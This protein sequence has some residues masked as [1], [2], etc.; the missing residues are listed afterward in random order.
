MDGWGKGSGVG[1]EGVN[2]NLNYLL[3]FDGIKMGAKILLNGK[4]IGT[5]SDQHRRYVFPIDSLKRTATNQ[6]TV[7]FD[8]A[9]NVSAGR[10]MA[11]SGGWDWAPY[12]NA[13]DPT[14]VT[15]IQAQ[16]QL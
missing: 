5:A 10:F 13:K 3:V 6:L 11:C 4:H 14:S 2:L 12:S 1:P 9:V 15:C 8:S 7:L 16:K